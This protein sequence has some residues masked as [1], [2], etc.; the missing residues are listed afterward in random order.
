MFNLKCVVRRSTPLTTATISKQ[1]LLAKLHFKNVTLNWVSR[2]AR[3]V[4]RDM[5]V[6]RPALHEVQAV[7]KISERTKHVVNKTDVS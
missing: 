1:D 3:F 2:K 7:L 6:G 4:T 5:I